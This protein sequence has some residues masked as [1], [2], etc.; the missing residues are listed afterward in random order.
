MTNVTCTGGGSPTILA[1][2]PRSSGYKPQARLPKLD[3]SPRSPLIAME[4]LPRSTRVAHSK[5]E[6]FKPY[7]VL[8]DTAKT[9]MAGGATGLFL[10][11]VRN[12]LS[13]TNV[14]IFSVFTRGAPII[15]LAGTIYSMR[16]RPIG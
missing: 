5:S 6:V 11:S 10:S 14:G 4:P 3:I 15:G 2:R 8:D 12:A 1:L 9:G 13:K 7:D 16:Q